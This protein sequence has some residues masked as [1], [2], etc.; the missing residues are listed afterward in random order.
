MQ[1]IVWTGDRAMIKTI[2]RIK[3]DMVMVFDARGKQL[4]EYQGMYHDVR[5]RILRDAPAGAVFSHWFG[6]APSAGVVRH[7]KW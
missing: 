1:R 6:Y 7:E 4:P 5:E 3:N 2:I